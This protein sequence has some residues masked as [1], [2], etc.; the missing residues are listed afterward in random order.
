LSSGSD[1]NTA[2]NEELGE[3]AGD[4]SGN[5]TA[6]S[7]STTSTTSTTSDPGYDA[8]C[9][10]TIDG[11]AAGALSCTPATKTC[12]SHKTK[13]NGDKVTVFKRDHR[14]WCKNSVSAWSSGIDCP[15]GL[16]GG[17]VYLEQ[18]V[19][20]E[21]DSGNRNATDCAEYKLCISWPAVAL[22]GPKMA[23]QTTKGITT[24]AYAG[25]V[26]STNNKGVGIFVMKRMIHDSATGEYRTFK[27]GMC[28]DVGE[29]VFKQFPSYVKKPGSA[30]Q[31]LEWVEKA[32]PILT[33][34]SGV[35]EANKCTGDDK[36]RAEYA[37]LAF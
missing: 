28:I 34:S 13:N 17:G 32:L 21:D 12:F 8:R 24:K 33:N 29:N 9:S 36:V 22:E 23:I 1:S 14:N 16:G 26:L 15:D 27:D 2:G 20:A 10:N 35:P 25:E 19:C 30:E 37:I 11:L 18:N 7:T 5:A 4:S 3:D 6:V 31:R